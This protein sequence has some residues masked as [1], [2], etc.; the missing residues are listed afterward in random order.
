MRIQRVRDAQLCCRNSRARCSEGVFPA[1][2]WP[3]TRLAAPASARVREATEFELFF[4]FFVFPPPRCQESGRRHR[5]CL[6]SVG[7]L[8]GFFIMELN[9]SR[10]KGEQKVTELVETDPLGAKGDF[11]E[12]NSRERKLPPAGRCAG[13]RRRVSSLERSPRQFC[14]RGNCR[15]RGRVFFLPLRDRAFLNV[16]ATHPCGVG[17]RSAPAALYLAFGGASRIS[18]RLVAVV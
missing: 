3:R 1:R 16:H 18:S 15:G 8:L 14:C 2:S 10:S 11:E 6:R 12:D 9:E 13:S 4:F 17:G 7:A 5:K